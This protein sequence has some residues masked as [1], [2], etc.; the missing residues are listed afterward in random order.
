MW[1]RRETAWVL[2]VP[3]CMLSFFFFFLH[4]AFCCCCLVAKSH[5]TFLQPH[6]L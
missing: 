4:F 6:G 1:G 3:A 5:L 2:G